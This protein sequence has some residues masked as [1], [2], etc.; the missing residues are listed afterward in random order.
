MT[1]CPV[2]VPVIVLDCPAASSPSAQMSACIAHM[3]HRS[4]QKG[5]I[6]P[7]PMLQKLS[8]FVASSILQKQQL[9]QC[10]KESRY[11]H[12]AEE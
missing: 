1:N 9:L 12:V 6:W 3:G 10:T 7:K 8:R 2:Y 4:G 5:S 11:N